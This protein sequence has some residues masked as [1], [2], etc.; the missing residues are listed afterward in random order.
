MKIIEVQALSIPDIKIIRFA[1]FSDHRGFF[2]EIYRKSDFDGHPKMAFL[3]STDFVQLNESFS[4]RGVVRGLHFQWNPFMGKLV[5]TISGR[6]VDLALD[7]RV[8]SP[9]LG[10]IIACDMPGA[11][12]RAY[13]EW[14]W[15]PPG[16][17]HGNYFSEPTRIEYAC[18]GAYN[19][20]CEACISPLS[21]DIDW[22]LC[23]PGLRS[24]FVKITSS[25][26][27]LITD[28]DRHGLALNRWLAGENSKNFV[29][30]QQ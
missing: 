19:P 27:L 8:N 30:N 21:G 13:D 23:D 22:S 12:D 25:P 3:K 20:E 11:D 17:A 15:I 10:K 18:S 5:R 1:R 6:M 7:I 28:K 29:Y 24:G 16:F 9:T 14:L 2:T 26:G 4:H